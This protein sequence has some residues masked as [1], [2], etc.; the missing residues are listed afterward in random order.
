MRLEE[1]TQ[2]L[3][4]GSPSIEFF[5]NNGK[6]I[7]CQKQA[8][9]MEEQLKQA[10]DLLQAMVES[11]D[12]PTIEAIHRLCDLATVLD[13][14]KLQDECIVVGDCAMKL[15]QAL[16]LRALEF[17]K[18]QAQTIA[19]IAGLDVYQSRACPLF[20]QAISVCEAFLIEDGSNSAKMT[21]L[22]ILGQAGTIEGHDTLCVQW[23]GRAIDL[24]AELPSAMVTDLFHGV[25]YSNYGFSL[26]RLKA[27]TKA[28]AA[29]EKAV[30]FWRS[31]SKGLDQNIYSENLAFA[32]H[33]Y[34]ATLHNIGRL[35]D[36]ARVGQQAVTLSQTLVDLGHDKHKEHLALALRN[37]GVTLY[38]IGRLEDAA[39]V[40]QEAVT[41]SQTLVD[42]GSDKHEE[43]LALAL[44]DYAVTLRKIGHLKD[45]ARAGQQA[46]TLSQT[47][48][49]LGHNKHKKH[50][51]LALN[52]YGTTL[53]DIGRLEDAA[54][55]K[56]EAVALSQTLVDLGNDKHKE[57]LALALRN[58]GVTLYDIGHFEDATRVEQ[59]AVTLLQTL[60]D[61]GSDKHREHLA[62]ALRN[63][64]VTLWKI[65]RLEDA[66]KVKQLSRQYQGG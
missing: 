51:A 43:H 1:Y 29:R 6:T 30:T 65:G 35:E 37:Y 10:E 31:L 48:V 11:R 33:N 5:T 57:H 28:L 47:L 62:L 20:I 34:G 18:E 12:V 64:A 60:V 53:H 56:Q 25:V 9:E 32:L 59:R 63:Y 22:E 15:A 38:A 17:Q 41:V 21:L 66:A 52:S 55:V 13:Q 27:D 36:A 42:L 50:L 19:R 8:D 4:T 16:G 40:K 61:L 58:Y 7:V 39:R 49:D 23:L 3:K 2:F 14:L 45:A 44:R 24:I 54:R 46:V 26:G